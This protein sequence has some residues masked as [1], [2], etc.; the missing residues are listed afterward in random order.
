M[1]IGLLLDDSLDRPD[2]VQQYVTTLGEELVRIGH[3]VV[4]IAGDTARSFIGQQ[5]V[6]SLGRT[7]SVSVNGNQLRIPLYL[8]R[9][10]ARQFWRDNDIDVLHIMLP[11]HPLVASRIA[12]MSPPRVPII[13]TF[14][15]ATE[16]WFKELISRIWA[17]ALKPTF[18]ILSR[19]LAVS[20]H[21]SEIALKLFGYEVDEIRPNV[22]N[23]DFYENVSDGQRT[24]KTVLFLGRLVDRKGPRQMLAAFAAIEDQGLKLRVVGDGPLMPELRAIVSS[25][26]VAERVEFVGFVSE[27]QKAA[28]LSKATV[29]VFPSTGNESFG[30][31]LVEAMASGI[32]VL[33]GDNPGYSTVI[34]DESQRVD[35]ND[36]EEFATKLERLVQSADYQKSL[37]EL[38][39]NQL[40]RYDVRQEAKHIVKIYKNAIISLQPRTKDN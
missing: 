29:A 36:I 4:Y 30:I 28:E 31:V 33:G 5:S 18:R 16:G 25:L 38:Q 37:L 27:E 12:L 20:S 9:R 19:R 3:Q 15:I 26:G 35:P 40:K 39:A 21:A 13:G 7:I 8:S 17:I 24:E 34:E 1:K 32:P 10:R 11:S 23:V 14:H 2:G 22:V 6:V